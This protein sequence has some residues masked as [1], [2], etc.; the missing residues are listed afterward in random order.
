MS[1]TGSRTTHLAF[2]RGINVGGRHRLPMAD[3]REAFE[4]AGAA[5]VRTWIQSGNVL[6]DAAPTRATS[7]VRAVERWIGDERGFD[8]PIVVRSETELASALETCPFA[9]DDP[10]GKTVLIGFSA[11]AF[12]AARVAALDPDRSPPDRFRVIGREIHL[13][14]PDGVARSRCT[15]A[16]FDRQL[17]TTCTFR[18]LA[19]LGR[20]LEMART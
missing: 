11:N 16:W 1:R 2:L 15:N 12:D 19:T 5:S 8:A 4:D 13:S 6:F 14:C 17:D 20:V 10:D 9:G 18:N 3:L 7:I